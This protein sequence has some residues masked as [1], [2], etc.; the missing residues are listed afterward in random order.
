MRKERTVLGLCAFTYCMLVAVACW[1][2]TG[3]W[4]NL[5]EGKEATGDDVIALWQ[6]VPG[7][8]TADSSGKGHTLKLKGKSKFNPDG[9]FGACLEVDYVEEGKGQGVS[10]KNN[11]DLSPKGAF[12]IEMWIKPKPE[13]AKCN[14]AFLLDKQTAWSGHK[15]DYRLM[16]SSVE[17]TIMSGPVEKGSFK[18]IAQMGFGEEKGNVAYTSEV[19]VFKPGQWYH[20]AFTYNGEGGGKIYVNG[21]LA[22]EKIYPGKKSM[23]AGNRDITIGDRG[24]SSYC[25]FPG[26][27]D[28]VRILNRAV[29]F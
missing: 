28:Q 20:L 19:K 9:K 15:E 23:Q 25:P 26:F 6:F 21:E 2:S 12:T 17:K 13:L 27:I 24:L 3:A 7:A 22:G 4:Q 14:H 11:P 29:E 5:Y 16:L 1:A 8:E 10:V 18:I